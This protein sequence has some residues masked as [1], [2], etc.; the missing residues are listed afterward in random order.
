[1]KKTGRS[2]V[3]L[4]VVVV[5]V[6]EG[7][8]DGLLLGVNDRSGYSWRYITWNINCLGVKKIIRS[9]KQALAIIVKVGRPFRSLKLLKN[10]LSIYIKIY[11][12][13]GI[14][15]LINI[16]IAWNCR[17][18][19]DIQGSGTVKSDREEKKDHTLVVDILSHC[20]SINIILEKKD[21]TLVVDILSHCERINIILI[22][23]EGLHFGCI[24]S[25]QN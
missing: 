11:W 1:M 9:L 7:A 24:Y 17:I 3:A 22:E 25:I 6:A 18:E 2:E 8:R 19:R 15:E 20:G 12:V 21:H 23:E 4:V 16:T 14:K 10:I 13:C 5:V